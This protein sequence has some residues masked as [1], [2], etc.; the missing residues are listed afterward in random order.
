M[1][2]GLIF[3]ASGALLFGGS[4]RLTR[5]LSQEH[6]SSVHCERVMLQGPSNWL[7][8]KKTESIPFRQ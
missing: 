8:V 6:S 7:T 2:G 1:C 5:F 3:C 4:F